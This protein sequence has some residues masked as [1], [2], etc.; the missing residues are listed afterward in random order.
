MTRGLTVAH[1]KR[2]WAKSCNKPGLERH[3]MTVAVAAG[4]RKGKPQEGKVKPGWAFTSELII[5]LGEGCYPQASSWV[6]SD[7]K[8]HQVLREACAWKASCF[9]I[10][11]PRLVRFPRLRPM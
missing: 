4:Q 10:T 8:F 2:C 11:R 9:E 6:I 5:H 7:F 1:W 3:R